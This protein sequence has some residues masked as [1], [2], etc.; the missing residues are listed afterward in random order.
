MTQAKTVA[1]IFHQEKEAIE[2]Y[3]EALEQENQS[4]LEK[5]EFIGVNQ[6]EVEK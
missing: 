5:V 3:L 1:E 4:I 6:V 2:V